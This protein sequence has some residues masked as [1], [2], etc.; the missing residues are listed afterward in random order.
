MKRRPVGSMGT[1]NTGPD[2]AQ[3]YELRREAKDHGWST[4]VH[5]YT[6]QNREGWRDFCPECKEVKP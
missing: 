5:G 6:T 1:R 4:R 3:G 2:R